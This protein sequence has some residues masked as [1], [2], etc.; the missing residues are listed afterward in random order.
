[1]EDLQ[2]CGLRQPRKG[3]ALWRHC[4]R[5]ATL[6]R[7]TP[8]SAAM[9]L[10]RAG[11]RLPSGPPCLA[12]RGPPPRA[13]GGRARRIA[14]ILHEQQ[15]DGDAALDGDAR[16]RQTELHHDQSRAKVPT[17]ALLVAAWRAMESRKG[18]EALVVDP[19]AEVLAGARVPSLQRETPAEVLATWVDFLAV[20]TRFIDDWL[21]AVAPAQ[22]VI[23]GAGLDTRA[24]R[25]EALRGTRVFEVDFGEV[26]A[27]KQ[28]ILAGETTMALAHAQVSANLASDDWASSLASAGFREEEPS[29]WLLEGLTGY[30]QEAELT[31]LLEE[32]ARRAAPGS[33]LLATFLGQEMKETGPVTPMHC[34]FLRE[35][36]DGTALLGRCGWGA[37][38]ASPPKDPGAACATFVSAAGECM[39]V[40]ARAR[41]CLC[42]WVFHY[43][44]SRGV[45]VV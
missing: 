7:A 39:W 19:Q 26:L 6:C 21:T 4:C 31:A 9:L 36:G 17:T 18:E 37:E 28:E 34:Y 45:P 35:T 20:R 5:L 43:V 2:A 13:G 23:L 1:M 25:L 41:T 14:N 38:A 11:R 3:P 12:A 29:C 16:L 32:A 22:L 27:A 24:Y 33:S 10:L 30:L 42:V 40:R 8:L 44:S 15:Q